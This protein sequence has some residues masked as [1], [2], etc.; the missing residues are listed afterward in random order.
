MLF[1]SASD[2]PLGNFH[3]PF[4]HKHKRD[5][6]GKADLDRYCVCCD[7]RIAKPSFNVNCLLVRV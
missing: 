7:E 6:K 2:L 5:E 1:P 4:G 3:T